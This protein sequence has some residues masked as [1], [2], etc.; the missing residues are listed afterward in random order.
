MNL[1]HTYCQENQVS[2]NDV[3]GFNEDN[4]TISYDQFQN[5]LR[6]AK[7]PFPVAQIE[8]MINY[9]VSINFDFFI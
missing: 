3:F 9:I 7:I 8:N 4:Y 6:K 2:L 1:I 5:G